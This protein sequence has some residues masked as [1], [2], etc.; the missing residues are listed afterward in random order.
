MPQSRRYQISALVVAALRAHPGLQGALILDNPTDPRAISDGKRVVFVEDQT[1]GWISQEGQRNKRRFVWTVGVINR[2]DSTAGADRAGADADYL[3]AVDAV[4][5]AHSQ[6]VTTVKEVG[7]LRERDVTFR[8]EG[9][10]VGGAL[11][12]GSFEVEYVTERRA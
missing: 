8:L 11:I 6:L 10:D 2:S 9:I 3:A 12:L 5:G 7:P 4:R 1:D